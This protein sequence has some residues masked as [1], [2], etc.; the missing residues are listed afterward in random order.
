MGR[1]QERE[2]GSLLAGGACAEGGAGGRQPRHGSAC[3]AGGHASPAYAG[4]HSGM[5]WQASHPCS[6]KC[7]SMP[8]GDLGSKW[9]SQLQRG[10]DGQGDHIM[11]GRNAEAAEAAAALQDALHADRP[12]S[13]RCEHTG[14]LPSCHAST[15]RWWPPAGTSR[16]GSSVLSGLSAPVD[17]VLQ[18]LPDQHPDGKRERQQQ[19]R[20]AAQNAS[21]HEGGRDGQPQQGDDVPAG[22]NKGRTKAGR[23]RVSPVAQPPNA[24]AVKTT[25]ACRQVQ[26]GALQEVKSSRRQAGRGANLTTRCTSSAP[27]AGWQT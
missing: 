12:T 6:M 11:L 16:A 21:C 9:N 22:K 4:A 5:P 8:L 23:R 10:A 20:Q 13:K 26:Q 7:H 17:R 2:G 18:Q 3:L 24:T 25:H 14:Q 1:Y 19:G 27:P 15:T